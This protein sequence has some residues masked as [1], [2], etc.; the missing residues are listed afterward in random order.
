MK[1]LI[2]MLTLLVA[3]KSY[4][5]TLSCSQKNDVDGVRV[6]AKVTNNTVLK[7]VA[8]TYGSDKDL[9]AEADSVTKQPNYKPRR[10]KGYVRFEFNY[11]VLQYTVFG[12]LLPESFATLKVPFVGYLTNQTSDGGGTYTLDCKILN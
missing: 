5:S 11:H 6:T 8:L 10:Y 12:V 9:L 4:A 2:L 3:T 1:N 7:K